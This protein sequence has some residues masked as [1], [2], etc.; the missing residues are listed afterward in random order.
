VRAVELNGGAGTWPTLIR[1]A[2]RDRSI[3][4]AAGFAV[5][6]DRIVTIAG[7]PIPGAWPRALLQR[8]LRVKEILLWAMRGRCR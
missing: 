6:N 7:L 3:A 2:C 8:M 4:L 1:V 5:G